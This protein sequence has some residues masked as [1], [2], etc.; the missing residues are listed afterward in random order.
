MHLVRREPPP[1][2]GGAILA[3]QSGSPEGLE[4]LHLH[5]R[6][7]LLYLARKSCGHYGLPA[8]GHTVEDVVSEVYIVVA[9]LAGSGRCRFDQRRC[10]ARQFLTGLIWNATKKVARFR[11]RAT[12]QPRI[13]RRH[14]LSLPPD[15]SHGEDLESVSAM[16]DG[17]ADLVEQRDTVD[18]IRAAAPAVVEQAITLLFWNQMLIREAASQLQLSR[19]QLTRIL[20]R[21][22][23]DIR[24]HFI[25]R[26]AA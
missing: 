17:S 22:Y 19:F 7:Y 9:G 10:N 2:L 21:F 14:S 12:P 11:R 5:H 24:Q 3:A 15:V 26:R 8:D 20:A 13:D 6:R 23:S 1:S 18:F 25:H 4:A 16:D